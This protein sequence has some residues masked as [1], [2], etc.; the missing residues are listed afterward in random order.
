[1]E[2]KFS[3][4]AYF[5][6]PAAGHYGAYILLYK[7][8]KKQFGIDIYHN[9]GK[10]D[11]EL[12]TNTIS[13]TPKDHVVQTEN[14]ILYVYDLY[15]DSIPE[16]EEMWK[17]ANYK[18]NLILSDQL[19]LNGMILGKKMNIPIVVLNSS[20]A[21]SNLDIAFALY[22]YISNASGKVIVGNAGKVIELF[23]IAYNVKINRFLNI[24]MFIHLMDVNAVL[25]AVPPEYP[26]KLTIDYITKCG[27]LIRED[28][29]DPNFDF[30][31]FQGK[32]IIFVSLGT[33]KKSKLHFYEKIITCFKNSF[34]ADCVFLISISSEE[35]R[36]QLRADNN[37][38]ELEE[39]GL[40][41]REYW[42]QVEILSKADLFITHG[43]CNS[44]Q[45]SL[46]RKCP[47][48]SFPNQ[49]DQLI[50]GNEIARL[51]FGLNAKEVE[52]VDS[53]SKKIRKILDDP[54]YKKNIIEK[55][56]TWYNTDRAMN[57]Y[58]NVIGSYLN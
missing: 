16:V 26:L 32:K 6:Y 36:E 22:T 24:P 13:L 20:F 48:L 50:I 28:S 21:M 29:V 30:D 25:N 18:P 51:K 40:F 2:E 9:R 15:F 56:S 52:D 57:N 5:P 45:E 41:I 43:G 12:F 1:M 54:S 3:R 11:K 31:K 17:S 10:V 47:M 39:L 49:Y 33:T 4:I 38:Q 23:E 44:Y 34:H 7:K 8:L 37:L 27:P 19:A 53:I 55:T 46:S 42:A 35:I 58:L 14:L